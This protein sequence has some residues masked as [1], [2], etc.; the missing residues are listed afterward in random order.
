MKTVK[1]SHRVNSREHL[2]ELLSG[3]YKYFTLEFEGRTIHQDGMTKLV[4]ES[5]RIPNKLKEE[6]VDEIPV[7]EDAKRLLIFEN[8]KQVNK[9]LRINLDRS[10]PTYRS[11][12]LP[13]IIAMASSDS[14]LYYGHELM[15][16]WRDAKRKKDDEAK[17]FYSL[18]EHWMTLFNY[19]KEI[20]E[21]FNQL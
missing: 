19:C 14:C 15:K 3:K 20:L 8:Y 13:I 12:W 1:Q 18:A 2:K 4:S 17:S 7:L 11:T 10:L 5:Y 16:Y 6:L 21:P 9:Y